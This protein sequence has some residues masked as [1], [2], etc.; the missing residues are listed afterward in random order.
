MP[1]FQIIFYQSPCYFQWLTLREN[2]L[3][4]PLGMKLTDKDLKND[5]NEIIIGAIENKQIVGGVHLKPISTLKVKLRQ[6]AVAEK[7]QN[8]R[9]GAELLKFAEQTAIM[10][11][12][13]EIEL[14]ARKTAIGFYQ[15]SGYKIIGNEFIEVSLPHYKMNKLINS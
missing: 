10:N 1:I 8:K 11:E 6:M 4:K 15:K 2:L 9:I 12:F 7:F 13:A 5:K 14:H 3:R